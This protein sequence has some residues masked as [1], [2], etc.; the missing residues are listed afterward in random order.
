VAS[1]TVASAFCAIV[2]VDGSRHIVSS[3]RAVSSHAPV[4]MRSTSRITSSQA[5]P[6]N[7]CL[8][9]TRF[10]SWISDERIASADAGLSV[11]N[12]R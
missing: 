9:S 4:W 7:V 5:P 8:R 10:T 3:D 12:D 11:V 6:R 1:F 2:G